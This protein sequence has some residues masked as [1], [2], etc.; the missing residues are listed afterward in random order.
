MNDHQCDE[1][2]EDERQELVRAMAGFVEKHGSAPKVLHVQDEFDA[3]MEGYLLGW[4]AQTCV[5]RFGT[6][7]ARPF[8]ECGLEEI[9][10]FEA[11]LAAEGMTPASRHHIREHVESVL[12]SSR[13]R[14]LALE[15]PYCVGN[16]LIQTAQIQATGERLYVCDECDLCWDSPETVAPGRETSIWN[17]RYGGLKW[18]HL[19]PVSER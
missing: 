16:G 2:T 17:E 1:L 7:V 11:A 9:T 5:E 13:W 3:W 14:Q 12:W 18:W 8:D 4:D 15:C 10:R 19:A 6:F